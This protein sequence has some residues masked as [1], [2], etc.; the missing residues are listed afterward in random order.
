[1]SLILNLL[2]S[3]SSGAENPLSTIS[4]SVGITGTFDTG[5]NLD[6]DTSAEVLTATDFDTTQGV[7]ITADSDNSGT[8]FIGNSDVDAGATDATSGIPITA[9]ES[10]FFS[11]SNPNVIY[12]IGSAVNQKVYWLAV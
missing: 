11:A 9:G 12:V 3:I 2:P 7:I 8:V 1:M 6:V 4:K 5:A 10:I